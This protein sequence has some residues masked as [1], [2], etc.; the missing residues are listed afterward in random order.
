MRPK[1][2]VDGTQ[3]NIP[4]LDVCAMEGRRRVGQMVNGYTNLNP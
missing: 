2:V 1:G 4:V 3:V